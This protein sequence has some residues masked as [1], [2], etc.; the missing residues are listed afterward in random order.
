MADCQLPLKPKKIAEYCVPDNIEVTRVS[1]TSI[2]EIY[3]NDVLYYE[4]TYTAVCAEDTPCPSKHGDCPP[5]FVDGKIGAV[6]ASL[7]IN[8]G[9][10]LKLEIGEAVV[11]SPPDYKLPFDCNGPGLPEC[12]PPPPP[13]APGRPELIAPRVLVTLVG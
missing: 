1:L 5:G 8:P 9:E 2:D 4:P 6:C 7:E 3:V 11:D 13:P 10:F 12:P